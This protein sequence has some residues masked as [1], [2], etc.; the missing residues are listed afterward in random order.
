MASA[1]QGAKLPITYR[2]IWF[3]CAD[4]HASARVVADSFTERARQYAAAG[5]EA[6]AA[7]LHA[8]AA[9]KARR[10]AIY[11]KLCMVIDLIIGDP[12]LVE[13][14]AAAAKEKQRIEAGARAADAVSV[15]DPMDDEGDAS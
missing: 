2:D 14:I 6:K 10:A 12:E 11:S 4:E 7:E 13:A 1:S 15:G 3:E 8:I 9:G 5:H